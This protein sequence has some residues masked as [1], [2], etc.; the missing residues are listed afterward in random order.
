MISGGMPIAPRPNG[1]IMRRNG[2]ATARLGTP[3][4]SMERLTP[5]R[6][7]GATMRSTAAQLGRKLRLSRGSGARMMNTG[8][9][10]KLGSGGRQSL[11]GS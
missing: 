7:N 4:L 2:T 10:A 6:G 1:S 5:R 11:A 8:R 3:M 9:A